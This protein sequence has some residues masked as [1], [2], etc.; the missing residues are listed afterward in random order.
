MSR[1]ER[2]EPRKWFNH[3]GHIARVLT[4]RRERAKARHLMRIGRHDLA[5]TRQIKGSEGWITN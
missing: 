2:E 4:R 3:E 1:T 5:D